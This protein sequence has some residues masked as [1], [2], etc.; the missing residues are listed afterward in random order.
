MQSSHAAGHVSASFSDP[1]LIASAGLVPV[2][3]LAERC[4][5]PSLIRRHVDLGVSTGVNPAG[6]AMSLV[7][8]MCV[9]ADSIEGV[10]VLR[11][12]GTHRLFGGIYAPSTLGSF[13]RSF[14]HGHVRQL[15]A[16]SRRFTANLIAHAG[17]IPPGEPIVYLD[18]DSKVKQVYGPAK[19]GASFGYTRVRGLHFQVVT[20]STPTSR[21]VVI[22]TR[23]RKGSAG[24]GKG[25]DTLVAE[26]IR[27]L[28]EAGVT[29]MILVR[30]DSAFFSAKLV[31][32]IRAAGACYSI[33]VAN[34]KTIRAAIS[35]IPETAWKPIKYRNAVWDQDEGRWISEAEIAEI[36]YTAF[37]SKKAALHA[38]GRLIVRRVRR[39]NP[40]TV[41]EGQGELFA[42]Y[43][44]HAFHTTNPLVIDQAE[45][46]HRQHAVIEQVFSDLEDGPLGHLPSG[47]FNANAAWL[48]LAGIAHNLTRAAAT[49]AGRF[50]AKATGATVRRTLINIPARIASGAR[51]LQLH[52]PEYWPWAGGFLTLWARTGHRPITS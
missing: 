43:R 38:P 4:A 41:P 24:S 29:A 6:K 31:K 21:P 26:A 8:G 25:A 22:A 33:T 47:R 27:A 30:A 1:N 44:H 10:D 16:A 2:M 35:Q 51:R 37:T 14:T 17:L 13:L 18:V 48:A 11:I 50:H 32:A 15:Q 34:T 45:P 7:A 3:R 19:Q 39:L 5:L 9:G 46:T 20:A 36:P 23:L 12:G 42:A 52:L 40:A 28:R 49:L